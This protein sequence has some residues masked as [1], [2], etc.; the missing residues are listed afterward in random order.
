M[1]SISNLYMVLKFLPL[2]MWFLSLLIGFIFFRTGLIRHLI[3]FIIVGAIL[4]IA[5]GNFSTI[6]SFITNAYHNATTTASINNS[7]NSTTAQNEDILKKLVSY[8]NISSAGPTK[9]Y[10]W[11]VGKAQLLNDSALTNGDLKFSSD[12]QGRPSIAM[13]KLTYQMYQ[14]SKGSRQGTPLDPPN[15]T[16]PNN[17]YAII[18]FQLTN[19]TYHGYFYNRSHS[20]ADSLGGT[21]T[22]SS[23]N[24]F[25]A[26]T[27]SQNVGADQNGGMRAAEEI[28]ENYWK[29]HPNSKE[30]IHYQT[31]P[32]YEG[33]EK[34]PRGS[35]VNEKSSDGQI[36]VEIAVINDAEGY[37]I[38]YNDGTFQMKK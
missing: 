31:T 20:I 18:H 32:L 10:Y 36:N 16:W 23:A 7:D 2:I 24:N 27:R 33:R 30:I 11:T 5:Y 1:L 25:T 26:G 8:T 21:Q 12:S 17:G 3:K 9:N 37:V 34:I 14:A 6:S 4:F 15:E 28:A 38:N 29:S 19:R 22:Y 35:I 13:G